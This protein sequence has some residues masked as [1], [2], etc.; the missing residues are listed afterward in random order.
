MLLI[1]PNQFI[2][3]D[4]MSTLVWLLYAK[5]NLTILILN[6]IVQK[7]IFKIILNR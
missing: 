4:N 7:Y 1:E 3:L 5:S 2:S 6:Y